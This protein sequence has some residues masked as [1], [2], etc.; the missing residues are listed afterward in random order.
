MGKYRRAVP[1]ENKF[2]RQWQVIDRALMQQLIDHTGL[3]VLISGMACDKRDARL[4]S[5]FRLVYIN[6][7]LPLLL[8]LAL[9]AALGLIPAGRVSAQPSTTLYSFGAFPGGG[10]QPNA[11]LI[12]SDNTL[13]GTT[14]RGG[15][16]NDGTVF[17]VNTDGSGFTNLYNFTNGSDGANPYAGL[18]LSGNTLYGT[19]LY[20]GSSNF[21]TVFAVNTDGSGFTNL[22]SFTNGSDGAFPYA[23]LILSGGTLYG[24]TSVGVFAVNTNGICFTNL[25]NFI[26]GGDTQWEG[27]V[28]SGATLY[29][30]V[31]VGNTNGWGTVFAVNTDGTGFTNLYTFNDGS[32]GANPY[33]GLILSGSIL[34][35]TTSRGGT[36]NDGTVFAINTDGSGFRNL[37]SF[38]NGSNGSSPRPGLVLSG[39]TLYGTAEFGGG[40]VGTVFAVNT[41][42][43]DF[44]N[45]YT[46]TGGSD[47]VL[48]AGGLILSGNTLYGTAVIGG[49]SGGG[50]VFSISLRVPQLAIILSGANVVLA[51]PTNAAG[52]TLE[53]TTNLFPA[54]WSTNLPSP[55]VINGQNVVTNAN[56]GTQQFFKLI[57]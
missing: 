10:S 26:G 33:A 11:G 24:A 54:V 15:P 18:I 35:G 22:Y 17:A 6:R 57:Q 19:A 36:L 4:R 38:T 14:S 37:Y 28:L 53:S 30:M 49:N 55:V 27:L 20:G 21:G 43:S 56:C 32:D 9:I 5:G 13:Y 16:L 2:S 25:Y 8:V 51:W 42:G 52:F 40:G 47:G 44:T 39:N 1:I 48:P 50:T 7:L 3:S 12:L 29:G 31:G 46:F 34:Y 23:G 45:L 41:D